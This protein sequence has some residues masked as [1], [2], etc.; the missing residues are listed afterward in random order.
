MNA[1]FQMFCK[2]ISGDRYTPPHRN[3]VSTYIRVLFDEH[4]AHIQNALKTVDSISFTTDCCI[5][6]RTS[7]IYICLTAHYIDDYWNM[8]DIVIAG[9]N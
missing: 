5:L 9:V 7:D 8:K 1:R 6:P 4:I 3:T 2:H